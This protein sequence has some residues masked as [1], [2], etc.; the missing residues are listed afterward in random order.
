MGGLEMPRSYALGLA[1]ALS[2]SGVRQASAQS[3]DQ[4]IAATLFN[5]GRQ[6]MGE[7][8]YELACAKFE[9]SHRLDPGGG[10]VLNL[11]ICREKQGKTMSAW[12][13][14][15]EAVALARRDGRSDRE[16][17][18]LEGIGRLEPGLSRVTVN[19]TGRTPGLAVTLDQVVIGEAA[20]GTPL[21][22]DPGEHAMRASA[23]GYE[24]WQGSFRIGPSGDRQE[25]TVPALRLAPPPPNAKPERRWYGWQTL[26]ADA[27]SITLVAVGGAREDAGVAGIGT[28]GYFLGAP[29]VHWAHGHAGKGFAS[30]GLRAAPIVLVVSGIGLFADGGL[31]S[32]SGTFGIAL[33][34]IGGLAAVAAPLADTLAIAREDVDPPR[35]KGARAA[36]S[37]VFSPLAA[38]RRDGFVLGLAGTF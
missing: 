17:L 1:L 31:D 5:E 10:T 22:V 25:V 37:F 32:G 28:L 34:A 9:Q 20:Y 27:A 8:K 29:T 30:F 3:V 15:R 23:A 4:A 14:Y 33:V 13:A 19:V 2:L 12:A 16:T 21:P 18:G 35:P 6:L 7:E 26:L 38:P 11:A 24:P 36:P